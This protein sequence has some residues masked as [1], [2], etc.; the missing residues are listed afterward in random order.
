MPW[1]EAASSATDHNAYPTFADTLAEGEARLLASLMDLVAAVAAYAEANAMSASRLCKVFG[2][3]VLAP[4]STAYDGGYQQFYDTW[5]RST[6]HFER[7]F[8]AYLRAQ[9]SL[10][11]RLQEILDRSGS[12]LLPAPVQPALQA[13]Y[14]L[15]APA[16]RKTGAHGQGSLRQRAKSCAELFNHALSSTTHPTETEHPSE[17]IVEEWW[18]ILVGD[19]VADGAQA[20]QEH[21]KYAR[22]LAEDSARIIALVDPPPGAARQASTGPSAASPTRRRSLTIDAPPAA[23]MT[24]SQSSAPGIS[25]QNSPLDSK[26]QPLTVHLFTGFATSFPNHSAK[27]LPRA[28]STPHMDSASAPSWSQFVSTGFAFDQGREG[29]NLNLSPSAAPEDKQAPAQR[30]KKLEKK[31]HPPPPEQDVKATTTP[32]PAE[33]KAVPPHPQGQLKV[34]RL[35]DVEDAFAD[36]YL[37]VM[38]ETEIRAKWPNFAIALLKKPLGACRSEPERVKW[39]V[40]EEVEPAPSPVPSPASSETPTPVDR[41]TSP[42]R[43]T[44]SGRERRHF[45]SRF[46]GVFSSSEGKKGTPGSPQK[47]KKTAPTN[48][49]PPPVLE[50]I[51]QSPDTAEPMSQQIPSEPNISQQ[52]QAPPPSSPFKGAEVSQ[53]SSQSSLKSIKRVKPPSANELFA[54]STN[55]DAEVASTTAIRHL[56]PGGSTVNINATDA[57]ETLQETTQ[58]DTESIIKTSPE[59]KEEALTTL[60]AAEAQHH[61]GFDN[62]ATTELLSASQPEP[63]REEGP[64]PAVYQG[65][66]AAMT[67]TAHDAEPDSKKSEE[68]Q[69]VER[70]SSPSP[71]LA[72]S[73]VSTNEDAAEDTP[74]SQEK[75]EDFP[76][77]LEPDSKT[78][79]EKESVRPSD[80]RQKPQAEAALVQAA[81]LEEPAVQQPVTPKA[82][83]TEQQDGS[84]PAA[85]APIAASSTEQTP[86][87]QPQPDAQGGNDEPRSEAEGPVEGP[88]ASP[89]TPT[90]QVDTSH[91]E[92]KEV[93]LSNSPELLRAQDSISNPRR[94][95]S[96]ESL[97]SQTSNKSDHSESKRSKKLVQGAKKIITVPFRKK[98]KSSSGSAAEA[99]E[100]TSKPALDDEEAPNAEAPP[101]VTTQAEAPPAGNTVQPETAPTP[102]S[103][104]QTQGSDQDETVSDVKPDPAHDIAAP[105]AAEVPATEPT[106]ESLSKTDEGVEQGEQQSQAASDNP[107]PVEEPETA[108]KAAPQEL[109]PDSIETTPDVMSGTEA[110]E[111]PT[112]TT[113]PESDEV[114]APLQESTETAVPKE[115]PNETQPEPEGGPHFPRASRKHS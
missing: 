12:T 32:Q 49:P 114:P 109:P 98:S 87:P 85:D 100:D 38:A 4:K 71:G 7:L 44:A 108:A 26:E 15:P 1:L 68:R 95:P 45:F 73:R 39:L 101:S 58:K 90:L 64:V 10:P 84:E 74:A 33:E 5:K 23:A 18:Q 86:G 46:S 65:K 8:L 106:A 60:A 55:T 47:G 89:K 61:A 43:S 69:S 81:S 52:L 20:D 112:K 31:S 80:N 29:M 17:P 6:N 97:A 2:F 48:A 22:I 21:N 50:A 103:P 53:G 56:S 105:I 94:S 111:P 40:V 51:P 28:T 102:L 30:A 16:G 57:T 13:V 91:A 79:E 59:V 14:S 70:P 62:P 27:E 107:Q 42:T 78:V 72:E 19:A 76:I 104:A 34:V 110:E 88:S 54:P 66:A 67:E 24:R 82:A 77:A 83:N 92:P 93:S 75:A 11:R 3:W 41:A 96:A 63:P 113:K 99:R 9:P 115:S 37:D 36:V 35:V 25:T